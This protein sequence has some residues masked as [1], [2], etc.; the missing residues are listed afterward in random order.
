MSITRPDWAKEEV[1]AIYNKPMMDLPYEAASI[2][3]ERHN[4][5][6]VQILT[7]LSIKIAGFPEDF[8]CCPQDA[9]YHTFLGAT[10]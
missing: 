10:T 7:L 9:R 5:N 4:P 1:I 6:A 2:H 8:G 3:R